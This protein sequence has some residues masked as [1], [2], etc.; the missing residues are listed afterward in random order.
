M[1]KTQKIITAFFIITVVIIASLVAIYLYKQ[2][3][4]DNGGICNPIAYKIEELNNNLPAETIFYFGDTCP[5]CKIVEDFMKDNSIET[6]IKVSQR[7]VYRNE[8]A[9][10]E[11][12]DLQNLGNLPASYVGAVPLLYYNQTLYLGDKDIICILKEAAGIK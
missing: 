11:M 5:H 6:K 9:A 3:N 2:K 1:D 8:S 4:A 12:M 7:E 10:K